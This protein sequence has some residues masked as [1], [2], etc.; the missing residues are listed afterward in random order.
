[1]SLAGARWGAEILFSPPAGTLAGLTGRDARGL[2][3]SGSPPWNMDLPESALDSRKALPTLFR[4]N[5]WMTWAL[6]AGALAVPL[7]GMVAVYYQY[8]L[9]TR[10]EKHGA[11][12]TQVLSVLDG[13][14]THGYRMVLQAASVAANVSRPAEPSPSSD[15]AALA[16]GDRQA[17]RREFEPAWQALERA[18]DNYR[19]LAESPDRIRFSEDLSTASRGLRQAVLDLVEVRPDPAAELLKRKIAEQSVRDFEDAVRQAT[20]AEWASL[21]AIQKDASSGARWAV[22]V[23]C[24]SW[25]GATML[26]CLLG[27]LFA[28]QQRDAALEAGRLKSR[29]LANMSHEIRTPMN[30]I[31]G[32]TELVLDSPLQPGQRR[33]LSMV[34]GSAE[35]L[36]LVINDILDF[37]KIEAG[38]LDLE[39]L[40]FSIVETLSEATR[41]MAIRA[42]QKGLKLICTVHPDIPEILVGDP[43]RLKQVIVNLVSNAI[44]FTEEGVV[45]V[46]ARLLTGTSGE[47]VVQFAVS[48]TGVGI[49]PEKHDWIF[50]S[51]AQVDGSV[52]RRYGGTGLGLAISRELV[53]MMG[54]VISVQS[55]PDHGSTFTF[56]ARFR[57]A[58]PK[59]PAA[60]APDLRG[61]R[62][63]IVDQDPASRRSLASMLDAWRIDAALADSCVTAVEIVKLSSRL[64][65]NFSLM[66]WS[67]ETIEDCGDALAELIGAAPWMRTV[68][69]IL[70]AGQ[71]PTPEQLSRHPAADCLVKPVSQSQFLESVQRALA[72]HA[73]RSLAALAVQQPANPV[74]GPPPAPASGATLHVLIVEDIV[75]NQILTG[76]LLRQRGYSIVVAC[77]GKEAIQL[78]D[79][80]RFDLVLMDIQMPQMGGVEATAVIRGREKENGGHTPIIAVTAHAMKGDRER[81]LAA[82]MDGY[83]TKPLRRQSL[84]DEIDSLT[85]AESR[86]RP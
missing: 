63:L 54:G 50:D 60:P 83:V 14:E 32:M 19:H 57:T 33:H 34:K 21:G 79:R 74:P 28:K 25:I 73:G 56:T 5:R 13:I 8:R 69:L 9:N 46:R 16:H 68:P 24:A 39:P 10:L 41:S 82:G 78:F 84:Y 81:Y 45:R 75:E 72:R 7:L 64:G 51:F 70:V 20:G 47:V 62:V 61:V 65:R 44:R 55:Q 52:S 6:L 43:S 42:H 12:Q 58:P 71:E 37:S 31:I 36:L 18:L 26:A 30:V 1:M 15:P 49:P 17:A 11:R 35:S 85:V 48:D 2:P 3:R 66:L 80:E 29:F 59:P 53:R 4:L 67:M 40:E 77:D 86:A 38:R 27:F 23:T 22:L 76:E